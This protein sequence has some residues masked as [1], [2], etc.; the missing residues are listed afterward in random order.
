MHEGKPAPL[1]RCR[2]SIRAWG[3]AAAITAVAGPFFVSQAAAG[4]MAP[5]ARKGVA[6]PGEGCYPKGAGKAAMRPAD[7]CNAVIWPGAMRIWGEIWKIRRF[8]M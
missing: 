7:T 8:M 1:V 4:V 2:P 6:V 5:D 3:P